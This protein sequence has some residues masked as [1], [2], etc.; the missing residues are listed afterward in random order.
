M[1]FAQCVAGY[2]HQFLRDTQATVELME[3]GMQFAAEHKFPFF[4]G[5]FTFM[6]GWVLVQ[7]GQ[8]EEG[9]TQMRKGLTTFQTTGTEDIRSLMLA[10]LAEALGLAGQAKKG[11]G[12][13]TEALAFVERTEERFYEAEIYRIRGEL[14]LAEDNEVEAATNF[15]KA[16]QVAHHQGAKSWEL[17]ATMSMSRLLM[18]QGLLD[19]GHEILSLVYDW[20]TEGFDTPDLKDAKVLLEE[21]SSS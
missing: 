6:R 12:V 20:F 16:I 2:L 8:T 9:L 19:E 15:R 17:R 10:Q 21:L 4:L 18:K 7:E 5:L 11:Q 1:V 13:I 14:C 3:A